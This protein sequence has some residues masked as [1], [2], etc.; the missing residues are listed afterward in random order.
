MCNRNT[1]SSN[2]KGDSENMLLQDLKK[3]MNIQFK[4]SFTPR[5]TCL[6][7][8]AEDTSLR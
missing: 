4:K 5:L 8:I 3:K 2:K 7:T 6:D 1:P